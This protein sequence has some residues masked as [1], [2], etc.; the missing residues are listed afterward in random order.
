VIKNPRKNKKPLESS[1]NNRKSQSNNKKDSKRASSNLSR[2]LKHLILHNLT[3]E[4]VELL[5]FGNILTAKS[6]TVKRLIS[7]MEKSVKLHLA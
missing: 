6:P 5:K 3:S 7:E 2:L 1:N 4:S